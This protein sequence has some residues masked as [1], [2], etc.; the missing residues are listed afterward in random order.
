M[1]HAKFM[2]NLFCVVCLVLS[3]NGFQNLNAQPTSDNDKVISVNQ[4][5]YTAF[6]EGNI[7][8]MDK[9]WSHS[10]YVSAI[11]PVSKNVIVG[12]KG[13]RESFDGVFKRKKKTE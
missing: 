2:F 1:K 9:V 6:K 4:S 5:F 13:V 11:H 7:N 10:T 3:V 12:W 8:K